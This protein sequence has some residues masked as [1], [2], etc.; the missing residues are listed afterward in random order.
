[1][2]YGLSE[3]TIQT[4]NSIFAKFSEVQKVVIYG[5]RAQG[6]YR[7]GSDIDLTLFGENLSDDVLYKISSELDDSYLPYKF[8]ISIFTEISNPSLI[9]HIERVGVV[10][11]NNLDRQ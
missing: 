3:K 2:S 9:D 6:N 1:M 5:S 7:N 10:F 8:D 4:I 11:Y